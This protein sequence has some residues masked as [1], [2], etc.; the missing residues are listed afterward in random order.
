[1]L[2]SC[3][4]LFLKSHRAADIYF[5][6]ISLTYERL[7]EESLYADELLGIPK[8]KETVGGLVKA[9]SILNE[10]YGS[11][12]VNFA[13]PISLRECMARLLLDVH[14]LPPGLDERSSLGNLTPAFIFEL[15]AAQTR[16]V[17]HLSYVLLLDMLRNQVIQPMSIISTC[18]LL[19]MVS[20][21]KVSRTIQTI[22][23]FYS[24][25]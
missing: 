15:T 6:P 19:S 21:D 23:K 9:R 13:R 17:E 22:K 10:C 11:I 12:F 8:P 24:L 2:A 3:V 1:M 25:C 5:V 18:L 20:V 4:E 14:S 7:L 16:H